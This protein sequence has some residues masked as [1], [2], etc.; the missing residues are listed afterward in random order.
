MS[1]LEAI[2][3][4]NEETEF[5]DFDYDEIDHNGLDQLITVHYFID[6]PQDEWIYADFCFSYDPNEIEFSAEK[7][8]ATRVPYGSTTVEYSPAGVEYDDIDT[9]KALAD[10]EIKFLDEKEN[11]IDKLK[12]CEVLRCDTAALDALLN[13]ISADAKERAKEE[14]KGYYEEYPE[15]LPVDGDEPDYYE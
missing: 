14:L 2:K 1:L 11:E 9:S 15:E 12:A 5:L 3:K 8:P 4:L 6:N 7:V 13:K 10:V